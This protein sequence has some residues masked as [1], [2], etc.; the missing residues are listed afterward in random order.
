MEE[1]HLEPEL[2]SI[3]RYYYSQKK[4]RKA[5][6]TIPALTSCFCQNI[7]LVQDEQKESKS[8]IF[9]STLYSWTPFPTPFMQ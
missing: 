2:L 7:S 8:E 1:K 9:T 6:L 5:I 4:V 3:K